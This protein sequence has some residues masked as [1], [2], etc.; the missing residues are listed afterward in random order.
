[1]HLGR[2]RPP[3]SRRPTST[4]GWQRGSLTPQM[5]RSVLQTAAHSDTVG[6]NRRPLHR[7][8]V[9]HSQRHRPMDLKS[10]RSCRRA[11]RRLRH[12]PRRGTQLPSLCSP[13]FSSIE[14]QRSA[15]RG[16]TRACGWEWDCGYE[17]PCEP[18]RGS[19][20]TRIPPSSI[21][22]SAPRSMSSRCASSALATMRA[23]PSESRS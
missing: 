5:S 13:L 1:M 11:F 9:V 12:A 10:A 8:E 16:G 19:I 18:P 7:G 4:G 2:E 14:V 6:T 20:L 3:F 23:A 17:G 15:T 22:R 21:D